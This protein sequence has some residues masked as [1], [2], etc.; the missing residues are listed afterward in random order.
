MGEIRIEQRGRVL[1]GTLANPP[2]GLLDAAI[3]DALDALVTRADS[4]PGVGGV[5]LTG[6]HPERFAAHYDVAEL[7]EGARSSPAMGRRA[8]SASLRAVGALRRLPGVEARL[9]GTQ[10]EGAMRLERFHSILLRMNRSGVVWVA[11]LNGSAQGGACELALACDFRI[12]AE[13]DHNI[14]QPEILFGFPPG[15]GGTQRLARML[16]TT[17]ALRLVLDG[18]PLSPAAAAEIGV[19]DEVVAAEE[20]VPRAVTLAERLGRRTKHA[21][22]ACKR[23]VYEGASL[24]LPAG[25]RLERAEFATAFGTPEA[26]ELMAA[27]VARLERT[28]ELPAYDREALEQALEAG[29]FREA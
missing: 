12:M 11:A 22:A 15:G 19:V 28:G 20:V 1:V 24:P 13:G 7:L 18:G 2:H 27:Y 3:V 26:D 21:V 4:D 17:R 9:E 5:V 8:A 23:A 14:G 10:A 29:G 6:G 25:L 16:G